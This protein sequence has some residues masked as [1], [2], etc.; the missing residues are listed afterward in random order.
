MM[1]VATRGEK[2]CLRAEALGDFE[3]EHVA[4]EGERPFQVSHL[5]MHVPNPDPRI[6]WA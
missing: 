1:M 5:Q 4:I 2:G 6:H 3:A